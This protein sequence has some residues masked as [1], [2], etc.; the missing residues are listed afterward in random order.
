MTGFQSR[1]FLLIA[2]LVCF[3][4][5]LWGSI[6]IGQDVPAAAE[7]ATAE[8]ASPGPEEVV[9]GVYINDIHELDFRTHSYAVDF[10]VW[11]RWRNKDI[12][13]AKTMEFMNRSAPDDHVRELLY[14]EPKVLPD[15]SFY[16]IV[17][18]QGRF[19]TKLKLENYPFDRQDLVILFEDSANGVGAQVY[20]ADDKPVTLSGSI[21]LPGFGI[22]T[23]RLEIGAHQ[24]PTNFGDPTVGAEDAYSRAAV[25]IAISRPMTALSVK[26]FLPILLIM[27]CAGLVLFIRPAFIDARVG[28]G[29]TALLTLVALQL[30]GGSS[31]P[32]VDYLTMV[33]KVYLASYG[34]IMLVLFRVVRASWRDSGGE[35]AIARADRVWFALIVL[36]YVVALTGITADSFGELMRAAPLAA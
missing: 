8:A 28:L 27:A 29:I 7:A 2:G 15:G 6:A 36:L 11:F 16:A 30:A 3:A 5:L 14:E 4:G 19:A 21:V 17:R 33:D 12:N 23:A 18:N 26:T 1:F 32:E 9:T 22:E 10:Y 20:R 25:S 31:L 34:F 24:Y 35:A 13:P